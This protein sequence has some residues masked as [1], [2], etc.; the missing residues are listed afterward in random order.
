MA[1]GLRAAGAATGASALVTN[2]SPALPAGWVDGDMTDLHVTLKPETATCATPAG[3]TLRDRKEGNGGSPGA[4]SGPG[5]IY[6]FERYDEPTAPGILDIQGANS[7]VAVICIWSKNLANSIWDT[8]AHT[9]A[10]DNTHAAN[11]NAAGLANINLAAGDLLQGS[12]YFSS[13]AGTISA[14]NVAATGCTF[15][16]ISVAS[17]RPVQTGNDLNSRTIYAQVLTGPSTAPPAH[18]YTNLQGGTG[19]TFFTRLREVALGAPGG[20]ATVPA[21]TSSQ[22]SWNAVAGATSYETRLNGGAATNRGNVLTYNFTGLAPSTAY[23]F[24]VRAVGPGGKSAWSLINASTAAGGGGEVPGTGKTQIEATRGNA[25]A[26]LGLGAIEGKTTTELAF[27]Y[28]SSLSGLVPK[29][30]YSLMD[31][32]RAVSATADPFEGIP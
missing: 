25:K 12:Q 20:L 16:L 31:H 27:D 14:E 19:H 9:A 13:D 21:P 15:G 18:G 2:I 26:A 10:I 30:R 24:E 5:V 3:W 32:C 23:N 7:A 28:W 8:S 29:E 4:D 11:Y 17:T 6:V 1:I 22:L